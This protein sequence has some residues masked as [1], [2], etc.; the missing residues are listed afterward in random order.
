[1]YLILASLAVNVYI[2]APIY[3]DPKTGASFMQHAVDDGFG[4]AI[5][6]SEVHAQNAFLRF[7][8]VNNFLFLINQFIAA[9]MIGIKYM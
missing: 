6:K 2:R 7:Q 9:G 4:N 8:I 1:M 3:R 5:G